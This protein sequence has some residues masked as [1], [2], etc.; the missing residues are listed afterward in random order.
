MKLKKNIEPK[1]PDTTTSD[2][3]TSRTADRKTNSF[4]F[5]SRK[6]ARKTSGYYGHG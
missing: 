2:T 6:S 1:N 5:G 3:D 4:R